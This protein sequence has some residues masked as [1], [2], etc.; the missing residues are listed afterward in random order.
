MGIIIVIV[1]GFLLQFSCCTASQ[2]TILPKFRDLSTKLYN[3][4]LSRQFRESIEFVEEKSKTSMP[5]DQV[6]EI[7]EY[8][9][10]HGIVRMPSHQNSCIRQAFGNKKVKLIILWE[11]NTNLEWPRQTQDIDAHHLVFITYGGTNEWWNLWPIERR[12]HGKEVH[13][14]GSPAKDFYESMIA[15]NNMRHGNSN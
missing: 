6:E 15:F 14:S 13:G 10:R 11:Y 12:V 4:Q 2:F 5:L 7:R 3:K 9:E 1:V 8:I